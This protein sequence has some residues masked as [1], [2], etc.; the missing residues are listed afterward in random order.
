M[1]EVF[2]DVKGYE[3]LYQVSNLGRVKSLPK[4]WV[5]GN[6]VIKSHKGKILKAIKRNRYYYVALCRDGAVK[7]HDIHQLVAIAFLNHIPNG[8]KIVVDHIDNN[9]ENNKV[10]NLQLITNRENSTKDRRGGSSK[11]VGVSWNKS[12][13]K[14]Q[15]QIY[16][17]GKHLHL[18]TFYKEE[19]AARAYRDKLKQHKQKQL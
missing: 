16:L 5:S 9:K 13:C 2:K 19:D 6:G 8:H 1:E 14:W 7:K 18:G 4:T 15:A 12:R 11:Y 10:D 17:D 3:C